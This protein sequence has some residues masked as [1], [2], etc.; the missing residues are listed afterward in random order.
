MVIAKRPWLRWA[1]FL[2]ML[3]GLACELSAM[4]S[5]KSYVERKGQYSRMP[6]LHA[7]TA[8]DSDE[9][10]AYEGLH[11]AV[12]KGEISTVRSLVAV[13][14]RI[15]ARDSHGRT[16]LMVAAYRRNKKVARF[17]IDSGANVNALDS[18]HYDLLTI[19]A[20]LND[21]E[22]V[23]LAIASG[24]DTGL[25]TSPY[26]GTALIAAAHLGHIEV[27]QT[28]IAGKAPLDHVYNL[29]WTALIEAIVLGDGGSLHEAIVRALLKAGA[30]ADLPDSAGTT[31]LGLAVQKRYSNIIHILKRAGA[32]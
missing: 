6:T 31:P 26:Q 2:S 15:N 17:L 28:L 11:A 21:I 19:A 25:V 7:Q 8:P 24:A 3:L 23:K 22:M 27:V 1:F 18:E 32:R 16:P 9:F 29:G 12:A 4:A 14:A 20:V 13:G 5:P 10:V 30:R